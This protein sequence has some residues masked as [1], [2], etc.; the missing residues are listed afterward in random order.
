MKSIKI[1]Y[2]NALTL[3]ALLLMFFGTTR[4]QHAAQETY[5]DALKKELETKWPGNRTIN[6]VF[7]GHSVPTGYRTLGVVKT[8]QS[9]PYLVLKKIKESYPFAVV[10]T[11]TTSIG[12][13]QAEQGAKRF[14]KEVLVHRPDVLFIDYAL[15]DRSIGLKR[16]RAAWESMIREAKSYGTKVI[17]LTPTPDLRENISSPDADLARHST[18]IRQLAEKFKV[19]LVDSYSLFKGMAKNQPLEKFLAQNNHINTL[20]HERVAEAVMAF[21]VENPGKKE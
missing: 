12:G 19:G 14:E 5:L 21:F 15:N 7:H 6:L 1:K 20:G 16:A 8:L 17:L 2:G 4:A 13:E 10:N 9:Y 18:Q 3:I 11:I